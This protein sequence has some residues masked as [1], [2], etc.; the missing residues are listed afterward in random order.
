M[1]EKPHE[2]H[3]WSLLG[4]F[5]LFINFLR[6][7]HT[8][9]TITKFQKIRF[10]NFRLLPYRANKTTFLLYWNWKLHMWM[11]QKSLLSIKPTFSI[12]SY[13]ALSDLIHS[14]VKDGSMKTEWNYHQQSSPG[15][16]QSYQPLYPHADGEINHDRKEKMIRNE[17][18]TIFF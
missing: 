3:H 16:R 7:T 6:H 13:V 1:L 10:L 15:C 2:I 5:F 8:W 11:V 18:T 12:P 4:N 14:Y 9:N 17:I